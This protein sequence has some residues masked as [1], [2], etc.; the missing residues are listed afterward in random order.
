MTRGANIVGKPHACAPTAF[1]PSRP[2]RTAGRALVRLTSVMPRTAR[3]IYQLYQEPG[4]AEAELER[5][6]RQPCATCSMARPA[7]PLRPRGRGSS[8]LLQTSAWCRKAEASC[9]SGR[10][11]RCRRGSAKPTSTSTPASSALGFRG[12]I[13]IATSTELGA[14]G[15]FR[16][17][18]DRPGL[19]CRRPRH[20]G[21]VSRHGRASRQPQAVRPRIA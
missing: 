20:G 10:R 21:L 9:G 17:R 13:I 2:Q 6:P 16:R 14:D 8:G 7:M 15:G 18:Q 19:C 5:D 3:S 1:A 12:P 11:R 4:V